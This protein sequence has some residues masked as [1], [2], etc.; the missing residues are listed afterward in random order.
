MK[1][2]NQIKLRIDEKIWSVKFYMNYR[3]SRKSADARFTTGWMQF[4][5]ENHLKEGDVCIF[6]MDKVDASSVFHV[7][8]VRKTA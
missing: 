4:V 5:R 6:E 1:M 2:K 7:H 8:I 3:K